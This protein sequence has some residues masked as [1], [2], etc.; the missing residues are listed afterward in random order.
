M[1]TIS[2]STLSVPTVHADGTVGSVVPNVISF[3]DDP[4]VHGVNA[5][6]GSLGLRTDSPSVWIKVGPNPTDWNLFGTANPPPPAA[7]LSM[8]HTFLGDRSVT[9]SVNAST[10]GTIDWFVPVNAPATV[11]GSRWIVGGP[12][13]G[14]G[15]HEKLGGLGYLSVSASCVANAMPYSIAGPIALDFKRSTAIDDDNCDNVL[16]NDT[17]YNGVVVN[18][19]GGLNSKGRGPGFRLVVP[20]LATE[21]VLRVYTE[22]LL[23]ITTC[24]ASLLGTTTDPIS[25]NFTTDLNDPVSGPSD[26]N[27]GKS[28]WKIRYRSAAPAWLE[29]MV[30]ITGVPSV[31]H[32]ASWVSLVAATITE[33]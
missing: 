17:S 5:P 24:S 20:A 15:S 16:A 13:N 30:L 22:Q 26:T 28:E 10:E 21:S 3:D 19:G 33:G 2:A 11:Y 18:V 8:T 27:F 32:Q 29:V 14:G 9:A 25:T 12:V 4:R 7:A 31:P 23:C 1:K 6:V